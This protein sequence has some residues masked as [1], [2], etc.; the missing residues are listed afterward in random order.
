MDYLEIS[1]KKYR[2]EAN[3]NAITAFLLA[4]NANDSVSLG[5][6]LNLKPSDYPAM[7]AA[8]INEGERL[9]GRECNLKGSDIAVMC[10]IGEM[11]QFLAIFNRQAFPATT[12][13]KEK[14]KVK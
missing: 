9:D 3:W 1:G 2:I 5:N 4:V 7:M 13:E 12:P 8:C 14:K 11:M 6:A 10:G